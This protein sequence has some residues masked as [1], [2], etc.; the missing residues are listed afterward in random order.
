M[1]PEEIT[2]EGDRLLR[3]AQEAHRAYM[4]FTHN[5]PEYR[6]PYARNGLSLVEPIDAWRS[7]GTPRNRIDGRLTGALCS[8]ISP[9]SQRPSRARDR[10]P[11]PNA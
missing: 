6:H 4:F 5:H 9:P 1:T 2:T 11:E 7:T 3:A 8:V 10:G